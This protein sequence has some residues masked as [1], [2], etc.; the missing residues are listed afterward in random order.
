MR[1]GNAAVVTINVSGLAWKIDP[2]MRIRVFSDQVKGFV[3]YDLVLTS[4]HWEFT[5]DHRT[6]KEVS[7]E[8]QWRIEKEDGDVWL[9]TDTAIRYLNHVRDTTTDP[10]ITKNAEQS[11]ATLRRH[12]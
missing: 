3:I 11:L 12:H 1:S 6:L 7:G 2:K 4:K 5:P 9:T 8:P 10:V